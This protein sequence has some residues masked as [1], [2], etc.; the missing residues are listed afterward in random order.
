MNNP[1][2]I[3]DYVCLKPDKQ[4]GKHSQDSWELDYVIRGKGLRTIGDRTEPIEEGEVILIPPHI[5]HL[6]NFDPAET[7]AEGNIIN[8]AVFFEQSL[9]D[10]I[11][12]LFPESKESVSRLKSLTSAVS[13]SGAVQKAI[14]R[15][16]ISMRGLTPEY[17]LGRMLDLIVLAS[18]T[19]KCSVVGKNN[20]LSKSEQRLEKVRVFCSCNYSRR[21]SLNEIAS[22]VNMN[23]SA[24]CTFI[25]RHTGNSFSEYVNL[26]RLDKAAEMLVNTEK[27]IAEIAYDV[28]FSNVTYF[29]RLFKSRFGRPPG[30]IRADGR[31]GNKVQYIA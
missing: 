24:F 17:R 9:L 19:R 22:H 31:D 23:K 11:K 21:I 13:Y 4:I 14:V 15:L 7:D 27:G 6:W 16:L 18:N 2:F 8:I 30:A 1:A 28:G 5:P 26:Y 3:Y 10:R 20:V 12:A 29:N 25:R